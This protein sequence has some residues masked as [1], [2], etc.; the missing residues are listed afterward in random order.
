MPFKFEDLQNLYEEEVKRNPKAY[1]NLLV[2]LEKAEELYVQEKQK[3]GFKGDMGQSWRSWSGQNFEKLM[4]HILPKLIDEAGLPLELIQG[5]IVKNRQTD[6][7]LSR[8]KRNILV[9]FG[10]YGYH[11]PD[12]D[13]VVY[14]PSD[15]SV[16]A[17]ISCKISLR[18]RIAQTA[19]WK[20]RLRSCPVTRHIKMFFLTPDKDKT[21]ENEEIDKSKAIVLYELDVAYIL[22]E[23]LVEQHNLRK[24][25]RITDDLQ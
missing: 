8:V 23:N 21:F 16:K 20:L 6:E 24:L 3:E 4:V 15:A 18:E 9:D 17:I 19:Y 22:R 25:E 11:L 10:I 2:I 7:T 5:S 13:I 1:E 12:A 14:D